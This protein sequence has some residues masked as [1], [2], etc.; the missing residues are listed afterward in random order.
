MIY[1]QKLIIQQGYKEEY[2]LMYMKITKCY[3]DS[4]S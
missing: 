2:K 4:L 3:S 1:F